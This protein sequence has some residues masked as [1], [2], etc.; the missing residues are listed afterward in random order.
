MEVVTFGET[1]VLLAPDRM[2]PLEYVNGFHKHV[3]GAETNVAVG[4]ARMGHTV[5]WFSKLGNDPFGRYIRQ[6]VRGHG[7]DT[8]E[9]RITDEAPTGVFFKEQISPDKIQVYYYRKQSAASLMHEDELNEAYVGKARI[10]HVTALLR[11]LA[12][13]AGN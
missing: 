1:M 6:V 8:S 2:V 12:R 13:S 9:V 3:A 11:R 4:L 5:G 10:L 7:V